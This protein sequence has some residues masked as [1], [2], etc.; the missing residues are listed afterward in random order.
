M[1]MCR[2]AGLGLKLQ[3]KIIQV[4]KVLYM[5]QLFIVT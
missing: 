2:S 4:V 5:W 3:Q 1:D